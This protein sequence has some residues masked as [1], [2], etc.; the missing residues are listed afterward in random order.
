M[1]V[2]P[3]W[4]HPLQLSWWGPG[5]IKARLPAG[6]SQRGSWWMQTAEDGREERLLF[7]FSQTL[8]RMGPLPPPTQHINMVLRPPNPYD[9]IFT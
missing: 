9:C 4:L 8:E 2:L 1:V 5:K 6:G 7:W 3:P